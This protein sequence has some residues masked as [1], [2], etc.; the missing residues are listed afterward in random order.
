[1]ATQAVVTYDLSKLQLAARNVV[2]A[3]PAPIGFLR[4]TKVG[5]WLH[6]AEGDE[7][8]EGTQFAVNPSSFQ[9]GYIAWADT[10]S[11]AP[12]NKLDERMYPA[13]ET[14]PDCGE[15]PKGS[16][17]WEHQLGFAV[18]VLNG[19]LANDEMQYRSSSDGGKRAI[20]QLLE[21]IILA[22]P[23]NPGK[24]P[25]ITLGS[26]SYKHK[27]YGKIYAPVFELMRWITPP[28]EKKGKK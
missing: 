26:R 3:M 4:M 11:G 15:P 27:S 28:V 19:E 7:V 21:A 18:K 12:A 1:M 8:P 10:S 5:E 17:G 9:R 2:S 13:H 14:L 20:A 6:G 22:A 24:L 25:V 23:K 16:R